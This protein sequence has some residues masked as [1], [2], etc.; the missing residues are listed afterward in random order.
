MSSN[1]PL[2][3]STEDNSQDKKM[4]K[5]KVPSENKSGSDST[6]TEKNREKEV[7][8]DLNHHYINQGLVHKLKQNLQRNKLVKKYPYN[9]PV[10]MITNCEN[11][12]QKT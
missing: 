11:R 3:E 1:T 4:A 7:K 9:Y 10:Q 6:V 12:I 5:T 8:K 2:M